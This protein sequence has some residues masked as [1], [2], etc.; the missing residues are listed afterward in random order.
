MRLL[1]SIIFSLM[2]FVSWADNARDRT[3]FSSANRQFTIK[4]EQK[5]WFVQNQKGDTLYSLLDSGYAQMTIVV[6]NNGEHLVIFDDFPS[7]TINPFSA[8]LRFYNRGQQ[9]KSYK[10]RELVSSYCFCTHSASHDRWSLYDFSLSDERDI[11]SLAT[12]EFY[13][14][15]FGSDGTILKKSRPKGYK[16]N[17]SIVYADLFRVRGQR[18]T[19]LMKIKV[20]VAG[21]KYPNNELQFKAKRLPKSGQ[22]I[23]M[24]ADGADITPKRFR[25]N[26]IMLNMCDEE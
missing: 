8:A 19:Y 9:T 2:S 23:L 6:S 10:F 22:Q 4:L 17:A 5:S 24:I 20:Y 12:Y 15:E 14:Y 18:D 16:E 1:T 3:L 26:Y 25:A 11:F 7:N 13:E 21:P